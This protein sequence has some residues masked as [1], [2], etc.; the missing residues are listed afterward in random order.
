M[1]APEKKIKV[2]EFF[3][4]ISKYYGSRTEITQGI[5]S[6]YED[7]SASKTTWNL[8]EFVLIRAAY[9]KDGDRLMMEG[10]KMYYEMSAGALFDFKEP[11]RNTFEFVEVYGDR[12]FRITKIKFHYNY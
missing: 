4:H 11:A 2:I 6:L 3:E 10:K 12:V 5:Y 9:R 1:I 7:F 8:S